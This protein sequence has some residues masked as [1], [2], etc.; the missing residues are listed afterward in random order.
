MTSNTN[1]TPTTKN[2]TEN[3]TKHATENA[4]SKS[5]QKSPAG[6]HTNDTRD[7]KYWYVVTIKNLKKD[8]LIPTTLNCK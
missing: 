8:L 7:M 2:T 6:A 3:V 1:V 5:V 4:T